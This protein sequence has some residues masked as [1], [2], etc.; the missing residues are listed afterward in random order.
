MKRILTLLAVAACA[1]ALGYQLGQRTA[2]SALQASPQY[3]SNLARELSRVR[4]ELT[5]KRAELEMLRTRHEVDRQ[6]LELVRSEIAGYKDR[7]A[8]LEEG[9]RFYRSLMAPGDFAR[10]LSVRQPEVV[11]AEQPRS[12]SI[13][14]VAQQ[15]ARKHELLAGRLSVDV[16]GMRAGIEV[17]Y[18]LT[19][20]SQDLSEESLRLKF[21][22]FQAIQGDLVLPDG[23]DPKALSVAARATR[24]GKMEFVQLFPWQL[25]ERFMH[26]GK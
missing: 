7:A 1:A 9:L 5:E 26:V 16:I 17:S 11:A 18:P 8:E 10:G 23:F 15:E 13:R 2:L 19:E 22:Y 24:P 4:R 14:L 6:A 3:S 20:L 25:Q 12:Y 21:R